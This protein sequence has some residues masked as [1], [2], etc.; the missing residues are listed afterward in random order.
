V[1]MDMGVYYVACWI[2]Y[3]T[4][5]RCGHEHET[6]PSA[7]ACLIF[8]DSFLRAVANGMERSLHDGEMQRF[9]EE[10]CRRKLARPL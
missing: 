7:M 6:I 4:I 10:L 3:G 5:C 1:S 9:R 8:E 2:G